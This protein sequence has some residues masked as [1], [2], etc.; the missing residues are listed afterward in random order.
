MERHERW[1][2]WLDPKHIVAR[3][4]PEC[5]E[6]C[7]SFTDSPAFKAFVKLKQQWRDAD[8]I[9]GPGGSRGFELVSGCHVVRDKSDLDIV[10]RADLR[11]TPDC[12]RMLARLGD[13][14]PCAIDVLV[15]TLHGA[16][17][18]KEDM[19]ASARCLLRTIYGPRL[20]E[21]PWMPGTNLEQG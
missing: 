4:A 8:L 21:D 13:D 6:P 15:E 20:V 17:S 7:P 1:A 10:V 11:L 3:V 18:P 14:L 12:L 2:A 19:G 16:F 9:W 5:I